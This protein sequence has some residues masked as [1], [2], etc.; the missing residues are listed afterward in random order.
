MS[1]S[2]CTG[3]IRRTALL[4]LA[5]EQTRSRGFRPPHGLPV[6]NRY[7]RNHNDSCSAH[8]RRG[9]PLG[10]RFDA[11]AAGHCSPSHRSRRQSHGPPIF[12]GRPRGRI[13]VLT[14][15]EPNRPI[16]R[17]KGTGTRIWRGQP[18]TSGAISSG[19]GTRRARSGL[20]IR[21][22]TDAASVST[23]LEAI[24]SIEAKSWKESTR[25]LSITTNPRH[26]SSTTDS[27]LAPRKP[28]G[29]SRSSSTSKGHRPPTTWAS[30]SQT[31][32]TC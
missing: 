7:G 23:V 15:P 11:G 32:T 6:T 12:K 21:R 1:S 26:G 28:A 18:R 9:T 3:T 17:W 2:W 16:S 5:L 22:F 29:S 31:V 14:E 27:C 24:Y 25:T 13:R 30:A 20:E 10:A 19:R 4:P 8:D